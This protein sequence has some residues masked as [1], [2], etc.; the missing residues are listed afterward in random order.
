M[1]GCQLAEFLVKRGR[2]VTIVDTA[3]ELGDG[4]APE[5]KNRLFL[6]FRKKGVTLIPAV[7]FG[8]ITDKGLIITHE[9]KEQLIKANSIVPSMPLTP[10][11]ELLKSLEG[12][13]PEIYAIGDCKE[14]GLIPDAIAGGWQIAHKI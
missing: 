11:R 13:F 9:G 12:E 7:K 14:P 6:W 3:E 8:E 5:R 4:L 2:K 10:D 1:H